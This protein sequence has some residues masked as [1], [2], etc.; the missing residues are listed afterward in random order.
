MNGNS[1]EYVIVNSVV[2]IVFCLLFSFKFV[3]IVGSKFGNRNFV[4]DA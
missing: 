2:S 3:F 4:V 1:N